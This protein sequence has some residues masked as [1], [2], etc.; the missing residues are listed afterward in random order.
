M[1][2]CQADALNDLRTREVVPLLPVK[3][4]PRF[5]PR[6]NPVFEIE[7]TAYVMATHLIASVPVRELGTPVMS[8]ADQDS[9]ILGANV[10]LVS[11]Y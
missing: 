8:L 4:T 10:M 1:L 5:L 3:S 2:D 6:L 9:T 7:G 11:G